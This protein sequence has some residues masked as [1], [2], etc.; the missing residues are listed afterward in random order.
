[1][2]RRRVSYTDWEWEQRIAAEA[3]R[4]RETPPEVDPDDLLQHEIERGA[5]DD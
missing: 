3:E 4:R 2:E 1:M 5:Y